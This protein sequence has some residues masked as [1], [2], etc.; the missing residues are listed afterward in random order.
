LKIG[1]HRFT[2]CKNSYIIGRSS[3]RQE[4]LRMHT[5]THPIATEPGLATCQLT[6][7][8]YGSAGSGKKV[9]IQAS[10]HADEVPA[11]LVAHCLRR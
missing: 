10:L 6:S 4:I 5:K 1:F 2:L 9:Y 8:H 3:R 11:L 7:C